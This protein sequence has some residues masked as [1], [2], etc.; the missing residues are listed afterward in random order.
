MP[1]SKSASPVGLKSFYNSNLSLN[2]DIS[3]LTQ[4]TPFW[5]LNYKVRTIATIVAQ[6]TFSL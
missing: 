3:L 6:Y 2:K 5:T 1:Y 4:I